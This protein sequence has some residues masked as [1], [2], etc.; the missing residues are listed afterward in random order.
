MSINVQTLKLNSKALNR[1]QQVHLSILVPP[2]LIL[3]IVFYVVII[4]V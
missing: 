3:N 1:L 2:T 4:S